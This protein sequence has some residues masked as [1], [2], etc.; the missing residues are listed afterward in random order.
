M[1]DL[2]PLW[3]DTPVTTLDEIDENGVL[4]VY[5]PRAGGVYRLTGEWRWRAMSSPNADLMGVQDREKANLS[6][7]IYREN[8][9]AG[10]LWPLEG[11]PKWDREDAMVLS[12]IDPKLLQQAPR[13]DPETV[14]AQSA[15]T[16]SALD[17]RLTLLRELLRQQD[18]PRSTDE[19][20]LY[21]VCRDYEGLRA[22][23]AAWETDTDSEAEEFWEH[24]EKEGWVS[25][26]PAVP[27]KLYSLE[28]EPGELL[29]NVPAICTLDARLWVE[30]HTRR[31]SLSQQGFIAMWFDEAI[32]KK[33]S[34]AIEGA[35]QDAGYTPLLIIR[36]LRTH[37]I[38]DQI[39]HQLRQSRFVVADLTGR[40]LGD[41]D[42]LGRRNVYY[43]A[44]FAAGADLEVIFTCREDCYDE[45]KVASDIRHF[46]V[47]LWDDQNLESFRQELQGRILARVRP[48]W[49]YVDVNAVDN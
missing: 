27:A 25:S 34:P 44:G 28:P 2:C 49:N 9:E 40:L 12:I 16:P 42:E 11:M 23:A 33:I 20:K 4:F 37:S 18:I 13:L 8:L 48:G 26:R 6:H 36:D 21:R 15:R 19:N 39:V 22:A 43:E 31:E 7:W 29:Y 47:V 14:A 41:S 35:I 32:R 30:E 46:H 1:P 24:L 17:R 5:S 10:L 3:G 38:P 45:K